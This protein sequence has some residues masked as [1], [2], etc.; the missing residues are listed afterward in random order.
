MVLWHGTH[1]PMPRAR[2]QQIGCGFALN[3]LGWNLGVERRHSIC[4]GHFGCTHASEAFDV[5]RQSQRPGVDRGPKIVSSPQGDN[6]L[7]LQPYLSK[8]DENVHV[9][10]R[11]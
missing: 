5:L 6:V 2:C 1:P 11:R 10:T 7:G 3:L 8:L 4:V 9:V